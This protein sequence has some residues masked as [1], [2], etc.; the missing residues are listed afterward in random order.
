MLN[1]NS[2]DKKIIYTNYTSSG[3]YQDIPD[4]FSGH[5]PAGFTDKFYIIN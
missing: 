3:L 1:K 2:K 4:T 5:F